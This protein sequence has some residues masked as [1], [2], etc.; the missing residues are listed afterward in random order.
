M[1]SR[2]AITLLELLLVLALIGAVLSIAVPRFFHALDVLSV[3]AAR[4]ALLSAASRT[5]ALAVA[6]GGADLVVDESARLELVAAG[7][8]VEQ[9]DLAARYDV[10]LDIQSSART[11]VNLRYDALGVGRLAGLTIR[12]ARGSAASG[13]TFSAYGRPRLW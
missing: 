6:R 7:V 13:V 8:L 12:L 3:R 11:R 1:R 9:L 5:R 4:D 2:P 10:Q